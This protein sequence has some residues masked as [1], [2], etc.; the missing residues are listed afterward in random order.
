M[1]KLAERESG[2]SRWRGKVA[3]LAEDAVCCEPVSAGK[4]PFSREIYREFWAA[5]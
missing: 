2:K 5:D 4:F 3:K 1:E